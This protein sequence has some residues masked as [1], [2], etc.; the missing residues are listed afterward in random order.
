MRKRPYKTA[1]VLPDLHAPIHCERSLAAVLRYVRDI[2]VDE[3]VLLGDFLDFNSISFHN[4]GKPR[5][6]E[7]DFLGRDYAIGGLVLD[8]IIA[9]A[10]NKNP[11]ARIVLLEGNHEFRVTRLLDSMPQLA[12]VFE[13]PVGLE[14]ERRGVE[15]VPS[16]S[17]G[18]LHWLGK[19]ACSHGQYTNKYHAAKMVDVHGCPIVYGHCH[20]VMDFPKVFRGKDETI[21]GVSLGCLID[22]AKA[23]YLRGNPNNWQHAFGVCSIFPDGKFDLKVTKIFDHRFVGPLNGNVYDGRRAA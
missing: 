8:E 5:L 1:V 4:S 18:K 14:L 2:W 19:L 9:A 10:R 13:V 7:G 6:V 22:T 12:G 21:A 15:W 16:W 3:L 17:E 23:T 20:D 11:N